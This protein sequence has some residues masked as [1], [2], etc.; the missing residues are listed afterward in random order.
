MKN[1]PKVPRLMKAGRIFPLI[2]V[3]DDPAP[4]AKKLLLASKNEGENRK[5]K[6]KK[7]AHDLQTKQA[8]LQ[9]INNSILNPAHQ[10]IRVF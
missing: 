2:H 4:R 7:G 6:N 5:L 10:G 3:Q 1:T 8:F 9:D